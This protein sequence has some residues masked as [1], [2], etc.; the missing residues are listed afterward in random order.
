MKVGTTLAAT[1]LI[2]SVPTITAE[3]RDWGAIAARGRQLRLESR[4]QEAIDLLSDA[5]KRAERANAASQ[6]RAV[7]CHNLGLA[8][9]KMADYASA[10]R[11]LDRALRTW[12]ETADLNAAEMVPTANGLARVYMGQKRYKVAK[13]FLSGKY[14]K[15]AESLGPDHPEWTRWRNNEASLLFYMRE[16]A[17]AREIYR[18]V[19][20]AWERT[21]HA[22][23]NEMLAVILNNI[24]ACDMGLHN[25][26]EAI[27]TL[28]RV[29]IIYRERNVS[30]ELA[31]VL[32]STADAYA[33]SGRR[34]EAE[35][36]YQSAIANIARVYPEAHP[37]AA[38]ARR[39]YATSLRRW[40]RT[41]EANS[42]DKQA[43][44]IMARRQAAPS[45]SVHISELAG[46]R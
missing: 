41:E 17:R 12:A 25:V 39:H 42:F 9:L 21:W 38:T 32:L 45:A 2:L 6:W 44:A 37:L 46:L 35:S 7:L 13:A 30:D 29:L 36:Y 24:A 3:D 22:E 1:L 27:L 33:I 15:Y 8:Y 11:F 20:E 18:E 14:R 28:E 10:E 23:Q 40:G 26:D 19:L 31:Q 4:F 34:T 43:R 5:W 16:F